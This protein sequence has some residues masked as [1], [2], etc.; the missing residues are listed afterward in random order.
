MSDTFKLWTHGKAVIPEYTKEYT[1]DDNGLYMKCKSL[2][3][4]ASS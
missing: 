1:G 3:C 2:P 4:L